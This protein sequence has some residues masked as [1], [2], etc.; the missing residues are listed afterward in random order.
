MSIISRLMKNKKEACNPLESVEMVGLEPIESMVKRS[1]FSPAERVEAVEKVEPI[2]TDAK[3]VFTLIAE[4]EEAE[5]LEQ[6]DSKSS[7]KVEAVERATVTE[8]IPRKAL[9]KRVDAV[10]SVAAVLA[11][12]VASVAVV[13][14]EEVSSVADVSAVEVSSVAAVPVVTVENKPDIAVD[15]AT[16]EADVGTVADTEVHKEDKAPEAVEA[17]EDDKAETAGKDKAETADKDE[18]ETADKDKAETADKEEN[19]DIKS[20]FSAKGIYIDFSREKSCVAPIEK[21]SFSIAQS[22]GYCKGF[23]KYIRD[24]IT[25][26]SFHVS[27]TFSASQSDAEKKAV[28]ALA[29]KFCEY[30][31][32]S[33]VFYNKNTNLITGTISTAP[34][35]MALIN[36]D[37]FEFYGRAVAER[38]VRE[39][40]C[41]YGVDYE[42]HS[43]AMITVEAKAREIDTVF[44]V[45]K[46]V[47][48]AE[49]KC[50]KFSDFDCY[51]KLG[52][53]MCVN[54]DKHI[55][56]SAETSDEACEGIS[57][58]YEYY[59][60]NITNYENKLKEMINK[61]FIGGK[62]ND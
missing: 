18:A 42:I 10:E 28:I 6:F 8:P 34:R 16:A 25:R 52:L 60:A 20:Y 30:G 38:V 43:N 26:K 41:K 17:V 19:T 40:A 15:K 1:I 2:E 23:L 7:E 12:E 21:L 32:I 53:L 59:V 46:H 13:P 31:I 4:M 49:F 11:E 44:R 58:L 29:D 54:P 45:G 61:A 50:G 51:R 56:L 3:S 9:F 39:M 47:F 36:G 33:N 5:K 37:Y 22:F 55:L 57:W 62:N 14:A 48:W 27:Y 24:S 35:V